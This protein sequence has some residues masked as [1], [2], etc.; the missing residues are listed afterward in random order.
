MYFARSFVSRRNYGLLAVAAFESSGDISTKKYRSLIID[1]TVGSFR[2]ARVK[3][4]GISYEILTCD[5][6]SCAVFYFTTAHA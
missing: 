2:E 4:G 6:T 3:K 1:C 5:R